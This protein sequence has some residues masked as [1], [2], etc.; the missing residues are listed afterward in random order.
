LPQHP[1]DVDDTEY[2]DN[3]IDPS[4]AL[5]ER[6][7]LSGPPFARQDLRELVAMGYRRQDSSSKTPSCGIHALHIS[8]RSR[9]AELSVRAPTI[10][11]L[12]TLVRGQE[13]RHFD[14]EDHPSIGDPST[15]AN[16]VRNNR[17]PL[18]LSEEQLALILRIIGEQ[19]GRPLQLG[20][21][22]L[23][24]ANLSPG[25]EM[26]S[27]DYLVYTVNRTSDANSLII[28]VVNDHVGS[29]NEFGRTSMD[30]WSG[31]AAA[32][33]LQ[34]GRPRRKT[35]QTQNSNRP[36]RSGRAKRQSLAVRGERG[37]NTGLQALSA[38]E[39]PSQVWRCSV[40]GCRRGA[41]TFKSQRE[42]Q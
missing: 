19:V 16:N 4:P 20:V 40:V 33:P 37:A 8:L 21:C 25:F 6:L 24:R 14:H 35:P 15:A 10:T 28:W 11:R 26:P 13:Y 1:N 9:L 34:R 29:T 38:I 2:C 3:F 36:Q 27:D 22:V 31:I 32:R 17:S 41:E 23:Q 30:H 5:I 39:G 18:C 42:L 12:R 7:H